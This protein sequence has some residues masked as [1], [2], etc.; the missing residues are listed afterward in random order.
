MLIYDFYNDPFSFEPLPSLPALGTEPSAWQTLDLDGPHFDGV[1]KPSDTNPQ[2]LQQLHTDYFLPQTDNV[3]LPEIESESV[4]SAPSD[5]EDIH[6]TYDTAKKDVLGFDENIWALP[7]V[8][9]PDA[10]AALVSWDRFLYPS[11]LEQ[12]VIYLSEAGPAGFDA[13][14]EQ[15]FIRVG[16]HL[17]SKVAR[18]D[19]L[20]FALCE[21]G[22]GRPSGLFHWDNMLGMFKQTSGDFGLIGTSPDV[23]DA[24]MKDFIRTGSTIRRLNDFMEDDAAPFGSQPVITALSSAMSIAIHSTMRFV[25]RERQGVRSLL[26]LQELFHKP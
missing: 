5:E 16:R 1:F 22:S 26:Q 2:V 15:A 11:H 19:K 7:G 8:V 13:T 9:R 24:V 17:P 18:P 3:P 10:L 25:Q 4:S 23:Q 6:A 21:L 14:L 20:I 12:K